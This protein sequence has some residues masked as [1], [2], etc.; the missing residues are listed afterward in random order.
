MSCSRVDRGGYRLANILH[1]VFG[2]MGRM[3]TPQLDDTHPTPASQEG[4]DIEEST[5]PVQ[6]SPAMKSGEEVA[7]TESL[8]EA[9]V[10]VVE[11]SRRTWIY[12]AVVA[13][14][15]LLTIAGMS[16][17]GGYRAGM[18]E[19]SSADATQ[20]AQMV[21]EQF[22]LGVADMEAKRF[23][24]ARQ[25][26]EWVIQQDPGFPGVTE[27]LA[28][29][30]LEQN[31]TAT[32]TPA[33]TPTLT[34][35]PDLRSVEELYTQAKQLMLEG[36][37]T[38]AI[39]SLLK[40]RRDAPDLHTIEVDG[41]LYVALRNRG[42]E[43]IRSTDLEGGTYD[44]AL[45]E[46]F[47]P[48][49]AEARNYRTWAEIYVTGA[50]FWE[51]DWGKAVE[52]YQQLILTA[53]FLADAS[54]WTSTDRYRIALTKFGDFL[55]QQGLFC[56]AYEQYQASRQVR[57]DP[58]LE[59]TANYAYEECYAPAQPEPVMEETFTPTPTLSDP[60]AVT[61]TLESTPTPEGQATPPAED[62]QSPTPEPTSESPEG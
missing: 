51:V 49:D 22:N 59:P 21:Q 2:I 13:I 42:L 17:F 18:T 9:S 35:T 32:S 8:P 46:R 47:G 19:R 62:Q 45:A 12:F 29:V 14:L 44:L 37:W 3:E 1:G 60:A 40:L 55:A 61:P 48:L 5:R 20:L 6:L 33:P 4:G 25:R 34:P 39:E 53:P 41:M 30:L 50:S 28:M 26:F 23:D 16:A 52:Y 7:T 56:E 24:L 58:S 10:P 54:G 57:E 15:T 43:K 11:R 36:D 27:K 38:N 31:T